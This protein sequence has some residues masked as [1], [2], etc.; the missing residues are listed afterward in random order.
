MA[1]RHYITKPTTSNSNLTPHPQAIVNASTLPLSIIIV[2]VGEA[3]FDAMEELDGD[4]VRLSAGGRLAQRDIVQFVPLRRLA[5]GDPATVR[6]R[7]AREVLAE[8]PAQFLGYMK[9]A[10]IEPKP[11]RETAVVLPPDPGLI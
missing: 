10:G 11:P 2:G 4:E 3:E 9:S 5:T 1:T 7:L 6:T 8:V